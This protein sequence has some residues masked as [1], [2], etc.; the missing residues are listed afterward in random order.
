MDRKG[1]ATPAEQMMHNRRMV[2]AG[3]A[4]LLLPSVVRA[5]PP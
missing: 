5:A 1:H 2:L 4:T 3:A